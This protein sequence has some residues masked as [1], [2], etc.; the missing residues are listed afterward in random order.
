MIQSRKRRAGAVTAAGAVIV[1][2]GIAG[3]GA[4]NAAVASSHREAPMIAGEPQYDNTDLYAFLTPQANDSVTLVASWIP[5]EEPAGGPNFYPWATDAK[6]DFNVD[7]NDDGKPEFVYSYEFKNERTPGPED[8]FTG[9]GTFLYNNGPVTSLDDPNLLFRQ[10]YKLTKTTSG[11]ITP[12][13]PGK[14]EVLVDGA[15]SAPSF[16]GKAS[17]GSRSAYR[18]NLMMPAI[19]NIAGGTDTS[20]GRTFAGQSDDPFFLDLRVF[21]LAYGGDLSEVGVDTLAGYNVNTIALQIP[22]SDVANVPGANNQVMGVW[23][24]TSRRNAAGQYV[25]VSRL[26]QPLVNEVVIPYQLKDAFN[27]IDPTKDAVALPVVQNPELPKILEAI[28]KIPAPATPRNDLV[29][30]FL[31]GVKGLNQN[32]AGTGSEQLRLNVHKRASTPYN[33][34]GVIAGDKNGFPNGRR[35]SDDVVDIALQVVEGKLLP[36][37]PAIVDKLGDG[38][39]RNDVRFSR[40]FPY[41]ATPHSGSSPKGAAARNSTAALHPTLLN[42][43]NVREPG[44]GLPALPIGVIAFG[45]LVMMAGAVVA[46]RSGSLAAPQAA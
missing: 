4:P 2:V 27:S 26:G 24:T 43:G 5:F 33:K 37:H 18:R 14:T 21:D 1:A 46:R 41:V 17:M 30:V 34:N 44:S 3:L 15:V 10:T 22:R 11:N 35:L 36:G 20:R 7:V 9:N 28:Y 16:V 6:Y 32:A 13:S 39:N 45:A 8:S 38:V 19:H 31:R 29:E 23:S 12:G 42:G 25:Q 40:A